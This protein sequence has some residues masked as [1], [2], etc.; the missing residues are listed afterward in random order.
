MAAV[1]A[2]E[3]VLIARH[4]SSDPTPSTAPADFTYEK[5]NILPLGRRLAYASAA[6]GIKKVYIINR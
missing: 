3:A 1:L 6:H 2:A 5:P 4:Q